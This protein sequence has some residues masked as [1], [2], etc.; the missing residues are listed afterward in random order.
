MIKYIIRRLL[1]LI[2]LFFGILILVF[3]ASRMAGD[4]VQLMTGLNPHITAEA[5]QQLREYYGLDK[6][7]YYQFLV[8]VW[9][10]FN[11]D[12]GNAYAIRGGL[13]VTT[14]IG[15]YIWET[16][17]LQLAG[18]FLSLT[19]SIPIGIISAKKQYSKLDVSVTTT[20]LLGTCIPVF[21]M[22]IIAI[23]VFSYYLGWLPPFGAHSL[24]PERYP[25][26]NY[27]LDELWHMALPTAVLTFALLA[28][29]VLLV[30]SSMLEVLR[31]D[32]I[33]AARASGLSERTVIYKH[34][35]RNALIPV[36]T[37]IGL[38]FGGV[39]AGAPI[40]ET[41]FNWPG[42][43]RLFVE[44]TRR[45]DFPVIM[46][47]TVMITMMTLF[48]NLITDLTYAYIDPRIRLE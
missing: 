33:L 22:G 25:F 19:I 23:I 21:Y 24:F 3:A 32:Y 8:Y 2:P 42:V 46:G 30:R 10:L 36:V 14:L 35:L 41:V 9:K 31:Q 12:L 48:A 40:T 4:P 5:K 47:I 18:L 37:Y 45:L 27:M 16:F 26:G 13:P 15:Q 7:L 11:V 43:G 34:A 6:P 39:L 28:P 17:K 29:V 44:A 20:S 1:Y 38:Y